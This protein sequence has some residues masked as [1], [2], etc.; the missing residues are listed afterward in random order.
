M[1]QVVLQHVDSRAGEV[2]DKSQGSNLLR[3]PHEVDLLQTHRRHAG[4]RPD[5]Q[6]GATSAGAVRHELPQEAVRWVLV[7][8]VHAHGGSDQR[9]VVHDGADQADEQHNDLLTT[10]RLIEPSGD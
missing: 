3:V 2:A 8:A 10:N 1:Q 5:D 9:D 7:Q 4:S 6:D